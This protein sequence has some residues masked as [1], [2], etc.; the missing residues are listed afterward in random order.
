MS[1]IIL[2]IIWVI[3]ILAQLQWCSVK[4]CKIFKIQ[5]SLDSVHLKWVIFSLMLLNSRFFKL[6]LYQLPRKTELSSQQIL[7]P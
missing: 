5:I 2:K 6:L 4:L 7:G 1:S 3:I